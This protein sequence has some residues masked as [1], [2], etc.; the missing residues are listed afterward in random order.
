MNQILLRL[1]NDSPINIISGKFALE[2][3]NNKNISISH[4]ELLNFLKNNKDFYVME[5]KDDFQ[6]GLNK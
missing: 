5:S 4:G 1:L 3:L 6:I 2:S